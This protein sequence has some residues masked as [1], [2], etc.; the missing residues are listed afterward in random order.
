MKDTPG[1]VTRAVNASGDDAAL[2]RVYSELRTLASRMLREDG[3]LGRRP[4]HTVTSLVHEMWLRLDGTERWENRAHFFGS[5]ARAAR[6]AL[7]DAARRRRA[8]K[9]DGGYEA[10]SG[11]EASGRV[12]NGAVLDHVL[13]LDEALGKLARIDERAARVAEMKL[14]GDLES[15]SIC[16]VLGVTTRTVDRD[17][18]FARAWLAEFLGED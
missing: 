14:F 12:D 2:E 3:A 6:R 1:T 8:K 5:A 17:W 15:R 13:V 11:S 7:V 10:L 9:R 4:E 18:V 16:L